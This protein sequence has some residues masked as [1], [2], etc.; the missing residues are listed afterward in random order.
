MITGPVS[1]LS[2]SQRKPQS[3]STS[4]FILAKAR[5]P[6][7]HAAVSLASVMLA[8][9]AFAQ[10][11]AAP[12]GDPIALEQVDVSGQGQG[13]GSDY[14]PRTLGLKRI[15]TPILDTPQSITVVPQQLI[16]DQ[17]DST[18]VEALHNVPGVTFFGGEGG[19]QGDNVS[20]HGYTARNDFYRDG[21]RDPGLVHAR[22]IQHPGNR[23]A[24]GPG[25][26]PVRPRLNRRRHQHDEQAAGLHEFHDRRNV[27]LHGS[28]RPR[29]RRHQPHIRRYGRAHH[30]ARQRHRCRRSRPYQY[31]AHRRRA[32]DHDEHDPGH[33]GHAQLRL[34]AGRQY[35]RLRHSPSAGGLFRHALRQAGAGRRQHL[36]W[37]IE[38]RLFRRR[39]SQRQ[40]R[41]RPHRT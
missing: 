37:P 16:Q 19:T 22:H 6:I 24:K 11:A 1:E 3:S 13:G 39:K 14:N 9:A 34:S 36:L 35:P 26:I 5:R 10:D 27:G 7:A 41:H 40:H 12:E 17:K 23:G 28:R 2:G 29:H 31:E 8:D 15:A 18:V 20:I 25:V 32:F 21:V 33:A 38:Q 30:S 4:G